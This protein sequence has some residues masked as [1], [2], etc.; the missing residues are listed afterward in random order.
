M[1]T[2][3]TSG[4]VP[5]AAGAAPIA[6]ATLTRPCRATRHRMAA[7]GVI[8]TDGAAGAWGGAVLPRGWGGVVVPRS[9]CEADRQAQ[10]RHGQ[11]LDVHLGQA[12]QGGYRAVQA[13]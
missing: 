3:I 13:Q 12:V 10:G 11:V 2:S 5:V 4:A 7:A 6:P 1:T 8:R 9:W